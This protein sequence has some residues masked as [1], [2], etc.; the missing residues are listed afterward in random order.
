MRFI[1]KSIVAALMSTFITATAVAEQPMLQEGK[2]TVYQRVVSNPGAVLYS[3]PNG[4]MKVGNP[5]TFTAYYVYAQKGDMVRV[6][7][8]ATKADG[9]ISKDLVTWWPQAITMVFS[10]IPP[11]PFHKKKRKPVLFFKDHDSLVK[12]CTA[13]S[14]K[15]TVDQY[16]TLFQ[17]KA[18]FPPDSPVIAIEPF[19]SQVSQR[20]FYLMPVLDIDTQFGESGT[21]LLQVA[22]LNPGISQKNTGSKKENSLQK[23]SDGNGMNIGIVFVV[24]TTIS[25]KPYI[26]S[27]KDIIRHIF[28]KLQNSKAKDN[29][30]IAVIGFRSNVEKSPN[31][32]YNTRI[33]SD[34]A[35]VK[36][37]QK[38]ESLLDD[39]DEAKAPTHDI[40]EDALSGVKDAID[41]LSWEKVD[42]KMIMLVTDAGPLQDKTAKTGMTAEAMADYLRLNK[43]YLTAIHVKSPKVAKNH[44]YAEESYKALSK[45]SNNRSNY[46]PINASTPTQGAAEFLKVGEKVADIFCK[47]A[48]RQIQGKEPE[49]TE[50]KPA[51]SA[52]AED[53]AAD[54][55]ETIGYAM[56]LQF[57]G[58]SS[59]TTAPHVVNSWIADSDLSLL[60]A[61]PDESPVPVVLPAVLL[62]KMQLSQLRKQVNTIIETAEQAFLKSSEDAGFNFYDQLISAA[63]QMTRDPSAFSDSPNANLAQKGV[64]LEVLDGLP[65]KSRILGLQRDDWSNM[66]VGQQREF[67]ARLRGLVKLYDEYDQ[68]NTHWES[69]GSSNPNEW[70]YRVPLNVLP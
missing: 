12:M 25:M 35:S 56:Q 57:V 42:G 16:V 15:D 17:S 26:D 10:D 55:S 13:D 8:S 7:A 37:R 23:K 50:V 14:I 36:D 60:E 3:D 58:D 39:L 41:K 44:K 68:D 19:T 64:L 24:D 22:S 43:I 31:T 1:Y 5:R 66:T 6:G 47:F 49:K 30:D 53:A 67:I 40:N 2:K 27:T 9:W 33:V 54:I 20:N 18:A 29:V 46:I 51:S 59:G 38:L 45:M 34:F 63:A 32:Q 11:Q 28:D 65:Y 4:Q 62:T 21:M 48:E 69:F 52:S 61:N 70:V